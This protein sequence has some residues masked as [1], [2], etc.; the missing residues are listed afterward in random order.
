MG[1][2]TDG[3]DQPDLAKW[4]DNPQL[5]GAQ[6]STIYFAPSC[7]PQVPTGTSGTRAF[8]IRA[9]VPVLVN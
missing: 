2:D 9:N 7:D 4:H 6:A 1:F 3:D 8:G 5:N